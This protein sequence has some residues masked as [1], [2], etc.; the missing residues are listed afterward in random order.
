MLTL[1]FCTAA[2]VPFLH[3]LDTRARAYGDNLAENPRYAEKGKHYYDACGPT[4]Q[5]ASVSFCCCGGA[6]GWGM[7]VGLK[8]VQVMG[9]LAGCLCRGPHVRAREGYCVLA[10]PLYS[11]AG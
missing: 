8:N 7:I 3:S 11:V 9:T 2:G 6:L 10:R 5:F 1:F 4:Y